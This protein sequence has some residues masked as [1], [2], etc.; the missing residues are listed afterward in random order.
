M[1]QQDAQVDFGQMLVQHLLGGDLHVELS[2]AGSVLGP[3][4]ALRTEVG[5]QWVYRRD[6]GK[7]RAERDERQEEDLR[8]ELRIDLFAM[9]YERTPA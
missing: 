2:P 1:L 6:F 9:V 5:P 7:L 3:K 4:S 8:L